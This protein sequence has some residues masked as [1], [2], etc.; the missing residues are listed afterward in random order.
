MDDWIL[1][2]ATCLS[3]AIKLALC[4]LSFMALIKYIAA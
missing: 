1:L 2:I 4:V 3:I